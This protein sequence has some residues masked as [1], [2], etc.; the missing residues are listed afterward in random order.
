MLFRSVQVLQFL[1]YWFRPENPIILWR[2]WSI[3][4]HTII[5]WNVWLFR[6]DMVDFEKLGRFGIIR[7][8]IL[9]SLHVKCCR[10]SFWVLYVRPS[11]E[12]FNDCWTMG[13]S[14]FLIFF[15]FM[16]VQLGVV[17]Q[18]IQTPAP[19]NIAFHAWAAAKTDFY[20]VSDRL[21]HSTICSPGQFVRSQTVNCVINSESRMFPCGT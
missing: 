1:P 20:L 6:H 18:L 12:C 14:F 17:L 11:V 16:S 7:A 3:D 15:N 2:Q 8:P 9:Y 5:C 4:V 21:I 13:C 19:R 10:E